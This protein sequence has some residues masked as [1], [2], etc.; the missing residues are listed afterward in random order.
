MQAIF[1]SKFY[2]A[3]SRKD[4][5][6]AALE[7]PI[8]TELVKQLAT[9]L[10]EEYQKAEYIAPD[11]VAKQKA[12]AT[13]SDEGP[14]N[15]RRTDAT[16]AKSRPASTG[17]S[18]G[19]S[20][21]GGPTEPINEPISDDMPMDIPSDLPDAEPMEEIVE[22]SEKITMRPIMASIEITD[23]DPIVGLLNS[24]ADT[25]G[26]GYAKL[27]GD[28]LWLYYNDKI[29]LNNVMESV[30]KLLNS[31]GYA[32]LEFNRLARSDNAMVFEITKLDQPM[33]AAESEI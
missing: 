15:G 17:H 29:N 24:T 8:N 27:V 6:H 22:E 10:D 19:R 25:T 16:S 3:S 33:E 11:Q 28:E 32:N 21:M 14:V 1:N 2:K 12:K 4:K 7:N 23:V 20:P 5:I 18:G 31:A 30:I 26:V 9:Y 13:E